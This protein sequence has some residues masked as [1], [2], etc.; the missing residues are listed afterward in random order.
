MRENLIYLKLNYITSFNKI[1]RIK[2]KVNKTECFLFLNN[3]TQKFNNKTLLYKNYNLKLLNY[4]WKF[5]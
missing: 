4:W 3:N 2:T 5:R 1:Q